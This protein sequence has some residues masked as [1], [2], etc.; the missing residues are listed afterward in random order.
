MIVEISFVFLQSA[1]MSEAT[2][3]AMTRIDVLSS[4]ITIAVAL[5]L[6]KRMINRLMSSYKRAI[7]KV[8]KKFKS[9][10]E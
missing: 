4:A 2:I 10:F 7:D 5:T 1:T 6:K 8:I 3:N 9:F